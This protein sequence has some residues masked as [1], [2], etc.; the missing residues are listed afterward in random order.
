MSAV[1][2]MPTAVEAEVLRADD[3]RFEAMRRGDWSALDAALAE[4]LTYVHSTA[5][6]ESKADHVEN[7]RAGKPHYRGIAPRDRHARVHGDIGIV[8]GVSEMHV[9]RDGKEQ[10]FTVRYLAVYALTGGAW[11]LIAWQSTRQPD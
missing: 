5:R 11:R 6:L 4:D 8:N 10:R 2:T 1:G 7:L 3:R 9:E